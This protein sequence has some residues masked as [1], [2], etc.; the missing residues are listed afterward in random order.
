MGY[1]FALG[2]HW[3]GECLVEELPYFVDVDFIMDS[4]GHSKSLSPRVTKQ[5]GLPKDGDIQFPLKRHYDSVN[6]TFGGVSGSIP[7]SWVDFDLLD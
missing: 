7:G 1:R 2:G 6:F 5:V 4:L 3:G